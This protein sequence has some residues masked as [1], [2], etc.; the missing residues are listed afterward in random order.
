M[1][2]PSD[3]KLQ[4]KAG[5]LHSSTSELGGESLSH[6][7][8]S[9]Q[10]SWEFNSGEMQHIVPLPSPSVTTLIRIYLPLICPL[11]LLAHVLCSS[12]FW[13]RTDL[14]CVL[15]PSH[16]EQNGLKS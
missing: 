11:I 6:I 15:V 8:T 13:P 12:S 16:R 7:C 9:Q 10:Q 4:Y 3:F 2:S 1:F 14:T 5:L